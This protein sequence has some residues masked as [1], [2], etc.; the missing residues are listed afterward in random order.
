MLETKMAVMFEMRLAIVVEPWMLRTLKGSIIYSATVP[1]DT[2]NK[3]SYSVVMN[4]EEE[5]S[6]EVWPEAR[7]WPNATA[8]VISVRFVLLAVPVADPSQTRRSGLVEPETL[9]LNFTVR[10]L[11]ESTNG[12]DCTIEATDNSGTMTLRG[13]APSGTPSKVPFAFVIA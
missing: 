12:L 11:A 3:L 9:E 8:N 6:P 5:T 13:C 10:E 7:I 1:F 4:C 2:P